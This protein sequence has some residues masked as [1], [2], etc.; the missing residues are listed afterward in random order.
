MIILVDAGQARDDLSRSELA[1]EKLY[2]VLTL[3]LTLMMCQQACQKILLAVS[4]QQHLSTRTLLRLPSKGLHMLLQCV[5]LTDGTHRM[6]GIY[7]ETTSP[8]S[9]WVD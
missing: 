5:A 3:T 7:H 6:T 2:I 1:L 8:G 9:N 4:M